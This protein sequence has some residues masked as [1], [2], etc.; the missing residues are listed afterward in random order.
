VLTAVILRSKCSCV[1]L[2]A[3]WRGSQLLCLSLWQ[4]RFC[5]CF[6][7]AYYFHVQ[8]RYT[9]WMGRRNFE[10]AFGNSGI[11]FSLLEDVLVASLLD[12]HCDRNMTD[13]CILRPIIRAI[14]GVL[15]VV[16]CSFP[17]SLR[18]VDCSDHRAASA[19]LLEKHPSGFIHLP[20]RPQSGERSPLDSSA[21][22]DSSWLLALWNKA[23]LRVNCS[24]AFPRWLFGMDSANPH[25][26]R[27]LFTY[28]NDIYEFMHTFTN[29]LW[30]S[31]IYVKICIYTYV[32]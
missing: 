27:Y 21:G 8:V 15:W 7:A 1:S 13:R 26:W 18:V 22:F 30:Y 14:C 2:F 23:G 28:I 16:D 29:N 3:H 24:A 6:P 4:S 10:Q 11:V 5:Q 32:L 19:C 20:Q 17:N 9:T 25:S 31:L 12:K